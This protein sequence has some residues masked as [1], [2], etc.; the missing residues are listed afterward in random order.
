[1]SARLQCPQHMKPATWENSSFS[2]AATGIARL[3][4]LAGLEDLKEST[5]TPIHDL[6]SAI[7]PKVA[8]V[9]ESLV[10]HGVLPRKNSWLCYD[11]TRSRGP[12][13]ASRMHMHPAEVRK[14][15]NLEPSR[16]RTRRP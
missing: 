12:F 11:Q 14:V 15:D 6:S 5:G 16:L 3:A 13:P 2:P 7:L 9:L 8:N 10:G 4:G 1:M